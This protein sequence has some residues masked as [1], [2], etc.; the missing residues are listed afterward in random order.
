MIVGIDV[1]NTAIKIAIDTQDDVKVL[2]VANR[3]TIPDTSRLLVDLAE[4]HSRLDVRVAS[5]N[6]TAASELIDATQQLDGGQMNKGRIDFR[7]ITRVDLPIEVATDHPDRVGIDR[8]VGAFGASSAY[9]LPLVIVDAGT[10]VTVDLVDEKG[11]YRGGA[12]IPGLEMQ[13]AALASGTDAL[14]H[15][16]WQ[17]ACDDS[18]TQTGTNTA[19]AIR[20]GILSSV[21]GGIERLVRLYGS[22][23]HVVVTGGDS[24]LIATTLQNTSCRDFDVHHHPHLV[25]RTLATL[26][27]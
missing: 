24:E 18:A 11:T 25:C 27:E 20:L 8:L 13:T 12:I 4:Q 23:K 17:T 21:V 3:Q 5:V 1:G 9:P 15:L 14:P 22:P 26:K 10:T 6:R 19:A 7:R 16:D 2:R